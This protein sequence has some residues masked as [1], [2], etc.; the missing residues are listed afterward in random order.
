MRENLT[1]N[2]SAAFRYGN[3][4]EY[5]SVIPYDPDD[6]Y[7][8]YEYQEVSKDKNW[9]YENL[10]K[11]L[12]DLKLDNDHIGTK[13]WSP[14]RDFISPGDKVVIKP[15]LV[16][17]MKQTEMQK[18]TTTHPSVVRV[19][20]DYCWKALAHNGMIIVGDAPS[21]ETDFQRLAEVTGYEKLVKE[22]QLRGVHVQLQDFRAVKVVSKNGIW[23]GEQKT[24]KGC[25]D[26][27]IVNL[28]KQSL[29]YKENDKHKKY[30]GGGY[31]IRQT[32]LHHTKDRQEY[33]IAKTVLEA[34]V[35]ISVPKLKTHRK[36]GI[37][38]CLK[39]LVGIN[40]DKNY[41]PHFAM[42]SANMGGDEMPSI[43][44]K[45]IRYMRAY[46]FLREHVIAYTWKYIG[47]LSVSL[48]NRFGKSEE[49]T[50]YAK[51]SEEEAAQMQTEVDRAKWLH[52]KI[53]GSVV[54]A[55]AWQGNIT[56]AKMILDLN[57]IFLYCDSRGRL[58]RDFTRKVFYIVDGLWAGMGNGPVNAV[59]VKTGLIGAGYNG[60]AMDVEILKLCNIEPSCIPLYK[61]AM[62]NEWLWRG[63]NGYHLLNG[64]K[65]EEDS[66][67]PVKITPPDNW[68]YKERVQKGQR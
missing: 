5:G 67:I 68:Q 34:N 25:S 27:V 2:S 51:K 37:T 22:M 42:G 45:N 19:I 24:E 63:S 16:L 31:D 8:E 52:H 53:S 9:V 1:M 10:R 6:T 12:M 7:L 20:I 3:E 47:N 26:K 21:A 23:T 64:E 18:Y 40:C 29:F 17:D 56:I 66:V 35:V 50:A 33:C 28:G 48:L 30:H 60:A 49:R 54:S 38:C 11:A 39:N 36:A 57:K 43:Q 15:N 13:D 61:Y 32:T 59:P 4:A 62:K 58:Q 46:N 44:T 14:F 41:L 65:I 55:G